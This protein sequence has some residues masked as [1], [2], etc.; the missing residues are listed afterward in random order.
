MSFSLNSR[1]RSR[2]EQVTRENVG[3]Q[4]GIIVDDKLYSAPVLREAIT[5]GHAVIS[6]NFTE[7]D[8]RRISAALV[9]PLPCA[10]TVKEEHV[11][12]K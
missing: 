5:G 3:R 6:G 8:A 4:L 12:D 7:D 10:V 11:L 2:F 9:A 1:G